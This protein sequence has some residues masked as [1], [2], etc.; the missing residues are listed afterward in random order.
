MILFEHEFLN[1]RLFLIHR[2]IRVREID[3]LP[4]GNIRA[5]TRRKAPPCSRAGAWTLP[6]GRL[7]AF[8]R[9]TVTTLAGSGSPRPA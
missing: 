9:A 1:P 4:I 8:G 7:I 2:F 5:Q 3:M 6:S